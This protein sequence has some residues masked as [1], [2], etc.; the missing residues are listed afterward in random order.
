MLPSTPFCQSALTGRS[1]VGYGICE[2]LIDDFIR[3]RPSYQSLIL[4]P[5]TR[6]RRKSD[7]TTS[8]LQRHI[9]KKGYTRAHIH[10][11]LVDLTSLRSVHQ[12]ADRLS[13]AIPHLDAIV[14]NAGFGGLIGVSWP[15]VFWQIF[16]NFFNALTYPTFKIS[17]VG[18]VTESQLSPS[19]VE[20][21]DAAKKGPAPPLG[22]IFASNVFGHYVLSHLLVPLFQSAPDGGRIIMISSLEA[23]AR[24]L[25]VDDMQG[26]VSPTAYESSKR[27]TDLLALTSSSSSTS[28]YVTGFLSPSGKSI[29]TPNHHT[30]N[31]S[32]ASSSEDNHGSL[33]HIT[34][35]D[36][37]Y[38]SASGN[39]AQPAIFLTHPGIC[40]TGFVPLPGILFSL[41][42]LF[43]YL[44]RVLGSPWH[45]VTVRKGAAAPAWLALAPK[46]EIA[47]KE[48]EGGKG[49]WGSAV[50]RWG[51]EIV[52]R[53]EVEGWGEGGERG[54]GE[55]ETFEE[56]GR[57]C[58]KEMEE[59]R[60][61]WEERLGESS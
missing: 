50:T 42:T 5:T 4:I 54:G 41:M 8:R 28:P 57:S 12:L 22:K 1:G 16:T 59:L 37:S 48:I 23:Y 58:W 9:K 47:D 34:L 25:N 19:E 14:C 11:E 21:L 53:T 29:K 35:S 3:T 56:A 6:D 44:A 40:S 30:S 18:Y 38:P 31:G 43:F 17:G 52:R 26:L 45:T 49:K 20:K 33:P 51:K 2:R 24:A 39:T 13:G 7:E 36:N 60:E 55:R 61:Q 32:V 15:S 10:P 46:E 27:L